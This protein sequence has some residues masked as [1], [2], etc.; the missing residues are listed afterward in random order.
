MVD[1]DVILGMDLIRS[2]QVSI[3]CKTRAVKCQIPNEP[4]MEWICS[5]AVPKGHFISY[6]KD[7][8]LVSKGVSIT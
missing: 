7:M 4:I 3:D 6:M 8:K 2:C 5:S 1:F